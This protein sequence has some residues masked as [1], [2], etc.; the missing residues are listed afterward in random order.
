MHRP[1]LIA[2]FAKECGWNP[3]VLTVDSAYYEEPLDN[4]MLQFVRKDIEVVYTKAWKIWNG[5]VR[6]G[7]IGL[8]SFTHLYKEA[9]HICNTRAIDFIWIPIPSFYTA[10]LGRLLFR[11]T[12]I[13]YGIDYIDPWVSKLAPYQKTFSKAWFSKQVAKFLEPIAVKNAALIS[14]VSAQYFEPVLQRNF[15]LK[16]ILTASMPYGFDPKDHEIKVAGIKTPWHNKG[17]QH[18]AFMYAGA[19]LPQSHTFIQALFNALSILVQQGKV[20]SDVHFYFLGTGSYQGKSITDYAVEARVSNF[21]TEIKQRF[22]F[23]HILHFLQ[24]ANGALIIGSTEKHYTASKTFQ[25]LLSGKPVFAMMH[26]QSSAATVLNELYADS[27]LVKYKETMNVESLTQQTMD[28]LDAYLHQK[29]IWQPK[30]ANIEKYSA[31]VSAQIL[32]NEV[33]KLFS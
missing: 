9:L 30:L 4:A 11:K 28:I 17:E 15:A 8:R 31:K 1:R 16:K 13:A 6:I 14:G 21:V 20:T 7:D 33:D 26:Q 19:F 29:D 5:P 24:N 18:K 23:I 25:S 2:N 22:P 10:L 12:K 32:F 3:V 27:Y